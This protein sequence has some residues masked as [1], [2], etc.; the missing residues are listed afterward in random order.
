M[1]DCDGHRE[2]ESTDSFD[3]RFSYSNPTRA[4]VSRHDVH[5]DSTTVPSRSGRGTVFVKLDSLLRQDAQYS[6]HPCY[7]ILMLQ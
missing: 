2:F 4:F 1:M 5:V 3:N 6:A 7:D